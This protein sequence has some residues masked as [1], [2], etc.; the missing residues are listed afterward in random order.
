[1][2]FDV[3]VVSALR[4]ELEG[5]LTKLDEPI[6]FGSL[7]LVGTV[8]GV[9]KI[10]SAVALAKAVARYKPKMVVLLGYTGAV[11][12]TLWL[13][14]VVIAKQVV[15]Y[16]LDLR[17]FGLEWGSSFL[18]DGTAYPAFL[19]LYSPPI[20]GVRAVTMGS[21][22]R[23]LLRSYRERHPEI[24]EQLHIDCCDMEGY[25]VAFVCR[26]AGI[27]C[28]IVRLVSDDAKG[29]RPKQFKVFV[30]EANEKLRQTLQLLLE[31]PREKSPTSL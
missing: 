14:D 22:D 26:D 30:R 15:Q 19:P 23:F 6:L 17:A 28:A 10:A 8:I 9:G 2:A 20:K 1:M 21:A 7:S 11:S 18:G 29:R 5:V 24:R 3:L 31:S 12:E 13:G 27:P 4:H 25:S 16:D